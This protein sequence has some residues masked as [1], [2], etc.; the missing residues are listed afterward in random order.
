MSDTWGI[1]GPLFITFYV[2]VL[3]LVVLGTIV[4]RRFAFAGRDDGDPARLT[5]QHIAF[6]NGGADNAIATSLAWL[7]GHNAITVDASG[8]AQRSGG[9]PMGATNLDAAIMQ[10]TSAGLRARSLL[11]TPRVR[12][13]L[14]EIGAG[15]ERD[16]LLIPAEARR[17]VRTGVY[18]LV[19][20]ILLGIWRAIDGVANERPIGFLVAAMVVAAVV[21]LLFLLVRPTRTRAGSKILYQVRRENLHLHNRNRPAYDTYG[22]DNSAL[23]VGLFGGAALWSISPSLAGH[24]GIPR[25]TGSDGGSSYV[26]GDSGS[27]D[28]GGGGDSGGSGCGGGGCGGGGC[29]G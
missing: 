20:L 19:G 18:L 23:A 26:G 24:A 28:S 7:H 3:V 27:G 9:V 5:P 14:D 8:V 29:G 12:A 11:N 21:T 6:L 25:Q 1:S 15:L 17:S 4:H 16:G 22:P 10:E 13:A 2:G